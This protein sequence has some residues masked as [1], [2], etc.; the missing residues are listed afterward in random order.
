M[1]ATPSLNTHT[2]SK[3]THRK[4]TLSD[5]TLTRPL[6]ASLHYA[7][8]RGQ[9]VGGVGGVGGV[10]VGLNLSLYP[11]PWGSA[12][13]YTPAPESEEDAYSSA[14]PIVEGEGGRKGGVEG[15]AARVSEP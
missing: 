12:G 3:Y 4:H 8:G 14:A 1:S 15:H 6:L 7:Q 11:D 2:H 10:H 5:S 13:I 9:G